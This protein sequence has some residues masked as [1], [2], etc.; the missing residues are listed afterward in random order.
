MLHDRHRE[1][2]VKKRDIRKRLNRPATVAPFPA[3]DL[4]E[5]MNAAVLAW[6]ADI[7][8]L[9]D[10]DPDDPMRWERVAWHLACDLFPNFEIVGKS[11]IGS[12]GSRAEVMKLFYE[13]QAYRPQSGGSKYKIFLRD[14]F[15]ECK[16]CNLT[17][18]ESLKGAMLKA[19]RRHK[20][21][22]YDEEL[23]ARFET[24]KALGLT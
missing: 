8:T 12:P 2:A 15:A 10:I 16:R 17:T 24:M 11:S 9:Y 5:R 6:W 3:A 23:L 22:R 20:S 7:F 13:F 21:N 18:A 19:S 4:A 1:L 14:H